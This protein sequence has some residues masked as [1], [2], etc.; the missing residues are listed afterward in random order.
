MSVNGWNHTA[1]ARRRALTTGKLVC[2]VGG[3][4]MIL[5]VV[6]SLALGWALGAISLWA[7]L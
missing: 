3:G 2:L 1:K 6:A 4:G 7:V 5:C